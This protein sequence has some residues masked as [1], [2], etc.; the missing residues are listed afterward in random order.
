MYNIK[1][2]LKEKQ[3]KL[4]KVEFFFAHR[5]GKIMDVMK[6]LGFKCIDHPTQDLAPYGY[7]PISKP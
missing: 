4:Q 6:N 5:I 1:D 7:F 3:E 2:A